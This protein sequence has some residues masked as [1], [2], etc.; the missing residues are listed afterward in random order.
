MLGN[1]QAD[2]HWAIAQTRLEVSSSIPT[3][4]NRSK[5]S[6]LRIRAKMSLSMCDV[7]LKRDQN[8][9]GNVP[10]LPPSR[11]VTL[12]FRYAPARETR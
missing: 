7:R 2:V 10:N 8:V 12:P 1:P 6:M 3:L 9:E 4:K 5:C 11:T